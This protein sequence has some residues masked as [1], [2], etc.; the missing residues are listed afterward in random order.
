MEATTHQAIL[1]RMCL[2]RANRFIY[3][4]VHAVGAKEL[5]RTIE[6]MSRACG[7]VKYRLLVMEKELRKAPPGYIKRRAS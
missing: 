5:H 3:T 6:R 7:V 1:A 2:N 4:M